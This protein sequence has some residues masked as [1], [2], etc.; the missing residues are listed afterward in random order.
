MLEPVFALSALRLAWVVGFV[1]LALLLALC[2][3]LVSASSKPARSVGEAAAVEGDIP[4]AAALSRSRVATWLL[5]SAVPS[6]LLL[7]VTNFITTDLIS[8]PLIWVGPLAVYLLS[9]VVVFSPRASRLVRPATIVAPAAITLLWVP[10]GSVGG[11]P[12]LPLVLLELAAL[13]VV[14]VALHGRLAADRPPASGLTAFYLVLS[15]GGVMGGA[16]VAVVAP[17]LFPGIWEY[18]LLLVAALVGLAVGVGRPSAGA[19]RPFVRLVAGAPARLGPFLAVAVI[20][21]VVLTLDRS[22]ALQAAFRWF[23]VGG[24]VLLVGAQLRFLALSTG[25]VLALAVLVLSPPTVF[26]ARSFFGVVQVLRPSSQDVTVL[27]NGTTVHGV[28]WRAAYRQSEPASYYVRSGPAGDVFRAVD[29]AASSRSVGVVGLGAGGLAAYD[30]PADRFTFFE[31]DPV[32]IRV[33]SDPTLFTYLSRAS[34][35]PSIVL[36]DARLSIEA[37]PSATYDL[38]VLDAF[39]SDAV[40]V[41]LL[42]TEALTDDIRV[43]R[44]SGTLTAH[45]S[46]RYYDL[47]PAVAA[48]LRDMG[49]E[50]LVREYTPSAQEAG[51]GAVPSRWLAATRDP[52]VRTS[53]LAAG[54]HAAPLGGAALTDDH[55]DILR[56]LRISF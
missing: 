6:G 38:L 27:M 31:I 30:Q 39:S 47:V 33:A 22:I 36:G 45:L 11:W 43:L 46:N 4:S 10:F 17:L 25:L 40:P 9:F 12:V 15:A 1:V 18:P 28:Q 48:A 5:W 44:A 21:I 41:H 7:A 29:G 52:A 51:D 14:A 35:P 53:L 23:L 20:T 26:Q 8:A 13:C 55:P 49:L 24:L 19:R 50:P 54:W 3:L 37:A 32:V 42:T 16:F 34:Q 2:G 56:L